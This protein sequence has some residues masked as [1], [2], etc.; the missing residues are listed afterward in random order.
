MAMDRSK[1]MTEL[2][3]LF[4]DV[5][6]VDDVVLTDATTGDDVEGWDSLG[7]V[8]LMVAVERAFGVTF[9]TDEIG[10]VERLGDIV[11]LIVAKQ[12]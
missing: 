3:R 6:D 4:A 7:H 8:R 9:T 10:D 1:V 5:L 11:D 12:G 2:A